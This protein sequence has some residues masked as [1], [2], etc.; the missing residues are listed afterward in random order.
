[1]EEECEEWGSEVAALQAVYE[2]MVEIL[3]SDSMGFK[4]ALPKVS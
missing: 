2:N 4:A 3:S 1:M